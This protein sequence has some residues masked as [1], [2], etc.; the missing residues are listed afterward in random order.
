M[1]YI[2]N[3]HQLNNI[4]E[5]IS[6]AYSSYGYQKN[7]GKLVFDKLESPSKARFFQE[8][9][10]IPFKKI[11]FPNNLNVRNQKKEKTALLGINPCDNNALGIFYKQFQ[12]SNLIIDKSKLFVL[13]SEC[14]QNE[15]CFCEY[16][17]GQKIQNYDLYLQ[18]EGDNKFTLFTGSEKGR[19]LVEKIPL[20]KARKGK[21][22]EIKR[23][24]NKF[25]DKLGDAVNQKEKYLEFWTHIS[26]NCFGCGS[27][28]TV[29]PLCFCFRQDFENNL[30]GESKTKLCWDSCFNKEFSEIQNRVD[31]RPKNVDR[32]YNWYHH[33]LVRGPAELGTPLCTGCGRCIKACPANLNQKNIMET[34]DDKE[35]DEG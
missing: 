30:N 29:C 6:R 18:K 28:S 27:C 21:P 24:D 16:F 10:V 19:T 35:N 15:Y 34:L 5:E 26:N 22:R 2:V 20:K 1:T 14:K 25:S 11:L 3:R 9:G 12:K 4:I 32:L 23:P 8:N 31:F 17:D 13:V 7:E 33:K